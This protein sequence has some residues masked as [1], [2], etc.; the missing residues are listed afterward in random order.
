MRKKKNQ[1]SLQTAKLP[2]KLI[3]YGG[4]AFKAKDSG[5][6][7]AY[8]KQGEGLVSFADEKHELSAGKGVFLTPSC[9]KTAEISA[10]TE[11]FKINWVLLKGSCAKD[12]LATL[13]FK[14]SFVFDINSCLALDS[15]FEKI[16]RAKVHRSRKTA[17]Q[18]ES[19]LLYSLILE[20]NRLFTYSS[21]GN[22][23]VLLEQLQPVFDYI[24]NNFQNEIS[25]EQLADTVDLSP[26]YVCRIFKKCTN[27]RPFEYITKKRIEEAKRLI[28]RGGLAVNE[29]ASTVGYSDCSYFCAVF[30]RLVGT[31][32][33][34]Y[35]T[36]QHGKP[37]TDL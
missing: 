19:V 31:S 28:L 29:I 34:G 11:D 12:I 5:Y 30:K 6:L 10:N 1:D 32:P 8:V 36:K 23:E 9:L 22:Q 16:T 33:I 2:L 4:S 27:M 15:Y 14:N 26:Q 24:D 37:V 21:L 17:Q 20:F 3:D 18:T 25:L 35:R 13:S 7:L